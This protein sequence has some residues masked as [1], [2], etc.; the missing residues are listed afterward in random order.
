[1]LHSITFKADPPSHEYQKKKK[2]I[3]WFYFIYKSVVVICLFLFVNPYRDS[4]VE[5]K[6][7][8]CKCS[9]ERKKKKTF[10]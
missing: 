10:S 6:K 1:M 7:M 2:L 9:K 8:R 5:E 3:S 4:G